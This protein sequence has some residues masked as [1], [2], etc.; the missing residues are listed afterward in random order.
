[1]TETRTGR[2]PKIGHAWNL[3][4][5]EGDWKLTDATWGSGMLDDDQKFVEV[6]NDAYFFTDAKP[7]ALNH[8]PTDPLFQ[9]LEKPVDLATF[10]LRKG[11]PVPTTS[12]T[13]LTIPNPKDSLDQFIALDSA[14]ADLNSAL[15]TLRFDPTNSPATL[16]VAFNQ[17]NASNQL[18]SDYAAVQK[19]MMEKRMRPTLEQLIEKPG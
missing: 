19:Q 3:V 6:F 10:K 7:F 9:L 14:A 16:T 11:D 12:A 13:T 5:V 1:M 2:I 17:F 4:R 18:F 15:R 8:Y